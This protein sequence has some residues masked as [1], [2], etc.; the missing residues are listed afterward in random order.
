MENPAHEQLAQ[1]IID[2]YTLGIRAYED[3][4]IKGVGKTKILQMIASQVNISLSLLT[5]MHLP[6]FDPNDFT[7][8]SVFEQVAGFAQSVE[9]YCVAHGEIKQSQAVPVAQ[10]FDLSFARNA[11][12]QLGVW[13]P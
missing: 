5:Q 3:A 12:K 13:T 2:A 10:V 9:D 1:D 11:I 6:Y 7:V 4:V 8:P